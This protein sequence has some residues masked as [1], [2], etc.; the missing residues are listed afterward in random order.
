LGLLLSCAEAPP[1]RPNLVLIIGDDHGYTDFGF[2]GSAVVQTPHLDRL[3]AEGTVFRVGYSTASV[4]HPALRTLLTGLHPYQWSLRLQELAKRGTS[5]APFEEVRY[6][7]TLPRLV[8]ARGYAAY[9]AGKYLEGTF[10]MGGFT[11]GMTPPGTE[12]SEKWGFAGGD[13]LAL[14]RETIAPAERFIDA[15]LKVPFFLWFAPVLPHVPHDAPAQFDE[16]YDRADVPAQTRAYYANISRFDA[17]VGALVDYLDAKGLRERTLIVYVVDNGWDPGPRGGLLM[18]GAAGKYSLHGRGL[19]TPIVYNWPGVVPA[20]QVIDALVST[21]DLFPTFLD[22]ADVPPPSD[23]FGK[24]LRPLIEGR[25]RKVHDAIVGTMPALRADAPGAEASYPS[26]GPGGSFCRTE[27]WHYISHDGA[28][29]EL[30]DVD[31]DPQEA[32]DVAAEH[33][34]VVAQ[35]RSEI[36]AW[37]QTMRASA[38]PPQRPGLDVP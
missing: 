23:R 33:P 9:Q 27:T 2:M 16:L 12:R 15:H 24:S 26:L 1:V 6:F 25:A 3:A 20:G 37:Q 13:Q 28:G 8:T 36:L 10:D 18:G 22:Y 35:L 7:A 4:C 30:Y 21:V 17:G 38:P 34:S 29:E 5:W 19:R 32:H 14:V 31:V 11:A